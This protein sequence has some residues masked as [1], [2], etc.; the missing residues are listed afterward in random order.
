MK[1]QLFTIRAQEKFLG[2]H[3]LGCRK[4]CFILVI[5]GGE[6]GGICFLLMRIGVR[7]AFIYADL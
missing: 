4:S 7:E 1:R 2:R 3:K 6:A 5:A